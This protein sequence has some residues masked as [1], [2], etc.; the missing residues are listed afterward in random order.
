MPSTCSTLEPGNEEG[1]N[2]HSFDCCHFLFFIAAWFLRVPALPRPGST[3]SSLCSRSV[4]GGAV[5]MEG[6]GVDGADGRRG[7]HKDSRDDAGVVMT[8]R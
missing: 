5:V 4:R 6:L 3:Q 1:Q 2:I 8:T 7:G